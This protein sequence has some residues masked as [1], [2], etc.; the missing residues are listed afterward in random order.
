[1]A[2]SFGI[3]VLRIGAGSAAEPDSRLAQPLFFDIYNTT[4]MATNA[5]TSVGGV[6]PMRSIAIQTGGS[7]PCTLAADPYSPAAG[8]LA[9]ASDLE[10]RATLSNDKVYVTAPC[11]AV[12]A[13]AP[14]S[15]TS[16]RALMRLGMDGSVRV[17][18]RVTDEEGGALGIR[19]LHAAVATLGGDAFYLAGSLYDVGGLRY[20]SS[21]R[22]TRTEELQLTDS[23]FLRVATREVRALG[24][25]SGSLYFTEADSMRSVSRVVGCTTPGA[26]VPRLP[27]PG[28]S[29]DGSCSILRGTEVQTDR[30][31]F[32][33]PAGEPHS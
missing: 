19:M 12:R 9:F 6:L 30:A 1:M 23:D 4:G 25:R 27:T 14:V 21:F 8:P 32:G 5:S 16:P 17:T 3:M 18:A 24:T 33:Q 10:G 11:Y 29:A 26:S 22:S 31:A 28:Y 7:T 2:A 20:M 13:G 15:P